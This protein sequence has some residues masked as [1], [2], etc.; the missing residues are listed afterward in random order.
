MP[1]FIPVLIGSAI[2]ATTAYGTRKAGQGVRSMSR[3]RSIGEEAED[4][5][6]HHLEKLDVARGSLSA[7]LDETHALRTSIARETLG[8]MVRLL[9]ILDKEGR[10]R[11]PGTFSKLGV[12]S[13]QVRAFVASSLD[14][15]EV[16]K[17]AVKAVEFG[18]GAQAMATG[19]ISSLATAST[20]TAI[21]ALSGAAAQSA[22]LAWLGG[23][24]LAAGGWGMAAGSLVA[25]GIAVAPAVA[26]GGLVLSVQGEKAKTKAAAFSAEVDMQCAAIETM[27]A[28]LACAERRVDELQD[29][30]RRIDHRALQQ[31]DDLF[32]M[33]EDFDHDDD[34]H[35]AQ[36]SSAMLLCKALSDLIHTRV[37]DDAGLLDQASEEL[38]ARYRELGGEA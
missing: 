32:A 8:S 35:V 17:G 33:A 36:L 4:R 16:F 5:H 9:Q 13:E 20:G 28:L 2:V 31:I 14:A 22:T 15:A 19:L 30:L 27:I 34:A 11:A 6:K 10:L 37:L 1:L 38:M 12:H 24:S 29:V 25:G 21:S 26:L 7:R 23:G 3:A 18:A